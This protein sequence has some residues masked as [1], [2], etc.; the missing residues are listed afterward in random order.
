[1]PM[2]Q[3][4]LIGYSTDENKYIII[5][6]VTEIPAADFFKKIAQKVESS[7]E[8]DAF[9]FV[10]GYNVSFSE[11]ISRAAQI[12]TDI[13]FHGAPIVYSWPSRNFFARY[14]ADEA[15]AT[16]YSTENIVELLK[17]IRRTTNAERIHLIA[18]SMGNRF[19]TQALQ[20]LVDQ[21]FNKDFLFNQIILA[22]PDIDAEIFVKH[23]APRIAA[24]SHRV[25]LYVSR[26]DK[27]LWFSGKIHGNIQ[28]AGS[29]SGKLAV[30]EGIDT[31][32]ASIETT[33]LLG[34]GY[35]VSSKA[36]I[37][38]MF[39]AIRFNKNPGDRNLRQKLSDDKEYWEFW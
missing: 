37:D 9:V 25:T 6:D 13:G 28:R 36:L 17:A 35:F 26:H 8:K 32:D 22:A 39:Q 21:G 31:V 34:H 3:W 7:A 10:H 1:M 14:K 27:P 5:K 11:S 4:S 16:G 15:T 33:D 30:I 12:A 20:S 24:S 23:I 29:I 2:P 19:L 18:H 38:D